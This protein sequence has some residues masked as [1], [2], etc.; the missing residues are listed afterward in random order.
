MNDAW[1]LALRGS[2]KNTPAQICSK[3]P[4]RLRT[5]RMLTERRKATWTVCCSC[6]A[7]IRQIITLV[8]CQY[9][10][11]PSITLIPVLIISITYVSGLLILRDWMHQGALESCNYHLHC[12]LCKNHRYTE[13][14]AG[15]SLEKKHLHPKWISM[16]LYGVK[17]HSVMF[18]KIFGDGN[19]IPSKDLRFGTIHAFFINVGAKTI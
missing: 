17:V 11:L 5:T 14:Q 3:S 2:Y 8:H 4:K 15:D 10:H 12:W 18:D 1:Q 9:F 13:A 6:S 16:S 7:N 19:S